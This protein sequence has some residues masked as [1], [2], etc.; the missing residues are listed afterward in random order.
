MILR[1][2]LTILLTP[3]QLLLLLLFAAAEVVHWI[4]LVLPRRSTAENSGERCQNTPK[5]CS[6]IVLNWNG[7][8]LLEECLPALLRAVESDGRDHEVIVVDNGSTD[9]SPEWV[10]NNHSC[11]KLVQLEENLG[12][13][14]GNNKGAGAANRPILVFLNNDMIVQPDF[15]DPLIRSLSD[16]DVFAATS[17][18]SFPEGKRREETGNTGAYWTRGYLNLE[19]RP[20]ERA[21]YRKDLPVLWA[22]GGSSAYHRQRFLE[23][24][25]FAPI[26]S[27][28]YVEDTDL[29]YRAWRRGWRSVLA[30]N[31]KVLHKHRSSTRTRFKENQIHR[32]VE[33]RKIWYLWRNFQIRTLAKHLLLLP[34]NLSRN[35]DFAAYLKS[36][37]RLPQ[38]IG[39]RIL[40]PGRFLSDKELFRWVDT[41]S[42]YVNTQPRESENPDRSRLK[43]LIISAY[44]P[45]LG[46]HGGA[47]R[48]FE[49]LRRVAQRHEVSLIC[50][51]ETAEELEEV[52]QV[53]PY[54][55]RVET[56]LRRRF[57]PLSLYPYEPF[58]EFN[59][60]E[61]RKRVSWMAAEDDFDIVHFEWTQM[62]LYGDLFPNEV[63]F[64]TEIEVNYAAHQSEVKVQKNVPRKIKRYY[65]TLQTL[66][67]EVEAC[68]RVDRVVCVTDIDSDFLKGYVPPEKLQIINTGVDTQYF[69]PLEGEKADPNALVY[70]GAFRHY[71]NVD[72]MLFFTSEVFPRILEEHPDA[73]LYIVG[74]SPPPLIRKMASH[75]NIT[76]TGFVEDIRDYYR[77]AQVVVVPLRTGVG[78]RGKILEGW[79]AGKAMVATTVACLGIR[80]VHGE[81]ILIADEAEDFA[82][83]TSALLRNPKHCERLGLAGRQIAARHYEWD[84]I[85]GRMCKL[86]EE[87]VSWKPAAQGEL[88]KDLAKTR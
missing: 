41:P 48:V 14:E 68:R 4:G 13:G 17:Q 29:S 83:W 73:H 40:E 75:S 86:Y 65:D 72:A 43:I 67:R 80:A 87:S 9:G 44:L 20:I 18:V 25:G 62:E 61:F 58:E 8:H 16:P 36:M 23:L 10:R 39:K 74:S 71:P 38:V 1:L 64:V 28:C 52:K 59:S 24:G 5:Q 57:E 32:L 46:K 79:S 78:I 2:G 63:Q 70:V 6:I 27:P 56:V 22:G 66:Y 60:S 45:H 50:F 69:Q 55:K 47:G 81:N 82:M 42:N 76:V 26:F 30:A 88:S 19:H 51:V 11:V 12:F 53:E 15:L 54:C 34:S 85:G 84:E 35:S 7:R 49:L 31:S 77:K 3:L 37:R 21:N 33:E